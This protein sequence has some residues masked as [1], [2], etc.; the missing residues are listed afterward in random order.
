V[1]VR[2]AKPY[3]PVQIRHGDT[4]SNGRS[5]PTATV[6]GA[7]GEFQFWMQG[8]RSKRQ[9]MRSVRSAISKRGMTVEYE[10]EA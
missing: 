1:K 9:L 8:R 7:E 3:K 4:K 2:K 10:E 6:Y 5:I